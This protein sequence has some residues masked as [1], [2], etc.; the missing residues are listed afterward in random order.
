MKTVYKYEIPIGIIT[1]EMPIGASILDVQ[2]QGLVDE[3]GAPMLSLWALVN[4]KAKHEI[5]KLRVY[6]TGHPIEKPGEYVGT[7]QT[8]PF[9]WHVF[10]ITEKL[11]AA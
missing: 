8:P 1:T 6:G 9:V 4:T 3:H 7:A 5:V 2:Y 10:K 11:R